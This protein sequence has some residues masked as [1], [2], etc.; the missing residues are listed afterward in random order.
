[1]SRQAALMAGRW[2]VQLLGG[3]CARNGQH[4]VSNFTPRAV[5]ALLARLALY[6]GRDHAREELTELLWPDAPAAASK[7]RFRHALSTLGALLTTPDIPKD[8]L[9]AAKG[10]CVRLNADLVDCDALA[11][12]A[13]AQQGRYAEALAL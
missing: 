12:E 8:T 10:R 5:G 9:L 6:P 1:V 2:S 4:T 7:S 13:L 3:L 11:F